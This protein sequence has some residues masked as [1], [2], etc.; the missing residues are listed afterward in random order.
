MT[1]IWFLRMDKYNLGTQYDMSESNPFIYSVHGICGVENIEKKI[2]KK[3]KNKVFPKL[4][5]DGR[6]LRDLVRLIKQN[7]INDGSVDGED[8]GKQRC[9]LAVW[10]WVAVM[11]YGDIVFVR[12][13]QDKVFI[14][15]ITGY[16]SEEFFNS[17]GCFRRPVNVLHEVTE[18]NIS[19]IIWN[20]TCGRK[21]IERNA[22]EE[23]KI[24]VR[25]YLKNNNLP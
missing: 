23:V 19:E 13:E 1:N 8:I 18:E 12:N 20:R 2:I 21:T 22:N 10:Y 3:N 17:H 24:M 25:E 15:R 6:E 7:L 16:V 5:I 14:C 11:E 9:D 4:L